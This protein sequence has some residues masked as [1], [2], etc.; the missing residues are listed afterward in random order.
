MDRKPAKFWS[1]FFLALGLS[2]TTIFSSLLLAASARNWKLKSDSYIWVANNRATV[3]LLLQLLS[4]ALALI[5]VAIIAEL[6]NRAT[7]IYWKNNPVAPHV[8]QFWHA[9]CVRSIS[10]SIPL[11]LLVPLLLYVLVTAIP[12]A[13]WAGALTPVATTV[14]ISATLDL[15][16]YQNTSSIKEWPSEIDRQGPRVR[17]S[18]GRFS[19]SVGMQLQGSLLLSASSAT[20][21]NGSIR[22]HGKLDNS[23]FTY[24][25]RSYGVG[26]SVGLSDDA[27]L[28]NRLLQAYSYEEVGYE[29]VVTCIHNASSQFTLVE[30]GNGWYEAYGPL[31]N[32]GDAGPEDS[33]YIGHGEDAIVAIGVGRNPEDPRRM[34]A[35]AAGSSY[36]HLNRTQ[37]SMSFQPTLFK[38][39]VGATG[40]NITVDPIRELDSFQ[41]GGNLTQVVM[42]QFELIS[43]DQTSLY[44]SVVGNSLND[45]ISDFISAYNGTQPLSLEEATLP[46]VENAL[47]AMVDD[48]LVAYASAQ[49][50]IQQDT[51]PA[52]CTATLATMRVGDDVYI[53]AIFAIN[54][55]VFLLVVVECMRTRYWKGM[56]FLDYLN[57]VSLMTTTFTNGFEMESSEGSLLN[58]VLIDK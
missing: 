37:C 53:H 20:P 12:S 19:Y 7:R 56:Y 39:N 23:R 17:N 24:F 38:V 10:W 42:R 3:Q 33:S 46:G 48:M 30:D 11:H 32:S 5:Y 51:T 21:I 31:P 47:Q 52:N 18:K 13:I 36:G 1:G 4:N 16:S 15:P 41:D 2:I 22:Q 58:R 6:T 40:R 55:A 26:S 29:T 27:L 25:G 57:P 44:T 34:L 54:I 49:M 28:A 50:M 43:N 35:I 45:S 8:V 9:L 14:A